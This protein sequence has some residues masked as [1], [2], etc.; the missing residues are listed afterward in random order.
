MPTSGGLTSG[1]ASRCAPLLRGVGG[2]VN[3][4]NHLLD[5]GGVKGHQRAALF[6]AKGAAMPAGWSWVEGNSGL[7]HPSKQLY[8]FRNSAKGGV[9]GANLNPPRMISR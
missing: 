3:G 6:S 9:G 4:V 7:L 1:V 5:R 8:S 2:L